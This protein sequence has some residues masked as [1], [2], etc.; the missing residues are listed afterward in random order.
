MKLVETSKFQKLRKKIRENAEREALRKAIEEIIET[1][2]AG[3][4]LKGEFAD[5]RSYGYS[6]KGQA[7]RLIYKWED[8]R[9]VLFSF[10][11][12]QGIYS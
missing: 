1:P 2:H 11:P 6:V 7:R 10:G 8:D 5:L 12:R 9:L 3:K 4:K